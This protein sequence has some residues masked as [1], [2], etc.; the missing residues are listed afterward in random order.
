[1]T[2]FP[3]PVLVITAFLTVLVVFTVWF[4]K[5]RLPGFTTAP[6]VPIGEATVDQLSLATL[7]ALTQFAVA[8]FTIVPV[9]VLETVTTIVIV[10]V[11]LL[12]IEPNV[13][14]TL[15]APLLQ[16][17]LGVLE[18]LVKFSDGSRLSTRVTGLIAATVLLVTT[19]V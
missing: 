8:V 5:F 13:T 3:V 2:R 15:L 11:S 14:V 16:T 4:P 10:S 12:A 18:Q 17:P 1:M 19:V 7:D 9:A 6:G